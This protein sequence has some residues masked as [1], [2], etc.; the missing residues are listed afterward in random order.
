[1]HIKIFLNPSPYSPCPLSLPH[2]SPTLKDLFTFAASPTSPTSQKV[3]NNLLTI[4]AK[5]HVIVLTCE[6][7]GHNPTA[8][9]CHPDTFHVPS[10][11]LVLVSSKEVFLFYLSP[12]FP[13]GPYI[14]GL[15][16]YFLFLN[17]WQPSACSFCL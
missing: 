3:T 10:T 13:E 7:S 2:Q 15:H 8:Y 1:M 4:I 16:I 6:C 9:F 17:L 11:S 5:A 12:F 14:P